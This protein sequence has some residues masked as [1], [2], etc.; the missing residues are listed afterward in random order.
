VQDGNYVVLDVGHQENG[1]YP[2]MDVSHE[3]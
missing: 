1:R 3:S 2:L